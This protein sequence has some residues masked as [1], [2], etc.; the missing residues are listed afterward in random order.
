[1]SNRKES[2]LQLIDSYT[3]KH[4]LN[5]SLDFSECSAYTI[6]LDL[7][8][9]RTNVS[10]ILNQ[11]HKEG[12]LIKLTGRPTLYLSSNAIS[13]HFPY[14]VLPHTI[15]SKESI[16]SYLTQT[17]PSSNMYSNIHMIGSEKNG[18]LYNSTIQILPIIFYPFTSPQIF[19]LRGQ[20]GVG[21][22]YFLEQLLQRGKS[23]GRFP[24]E[25][26]ILHINGNNLLRTYPLEVE[27]LKEKKHSIIAITIT[28]TL[29]TDIVMSFINQIQYFFELETSTPPLIA[30]LIDES[31]K[32]YSQYY[33]LTPF[34]A[35]F[36]P[37]SD[38]PLK[39]ILRLI[40]DIISEECKRLSRNVQ[41]SKKL[42]ISLLGMNYTSNI[43][44]LK[45][46]IIYAFTFSAFHS[47]PN[48]DLPLV[49]SEILFPEADLYKTIA[50]SDR[51]IIDALPETILFKPA[52]PINFEELITSPL[53]SK[54]SFVDQTKQ[55][56]QTSLKEHLLSLP[57]NFDTSSFPTC[58][59][60]LKSRL[61]TIFE[62]T[63]LI[64]DSVLF[65][66][67]ISLIEQLAL[68]NIHR[69]AYIIDPLEEEISEIEQ[70]LCNKTAQIVISRYS[71]PD[72]DIIGDIKAIVR[73][74]LQCITNL[75]YPIIFITHG[76]ELASCYA[77]QLNRF[78]GR[79][80]F[81][82]KDFT[83]KMEQL[84]TTK[85]VKQ[86]STNIKSLNS[87]RGTFLF[88]DSVSLTKMDSK[89]FFDTQSLTFSIYPSSIIYMK[90]SVSIIK[91]GNAN[92]IIPLSSK[93]IQVKG[94]Y[95]HYLNDYTLN[96]KKERDSD[97][98]IKWIQNL[99]PTLNGNITR[100][101]LYQLLIQI[102]NIYSYE[103]NNQLILDFIFYGNWVLNR[104]S[105]KDMSQ[106]NIKD[107]YYDSESE[108]F[109]NLKQKISN[110]QELN[111]FSFTESDFVVLYDCL[112]PYLSL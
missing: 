102:C 67:M 75:A 5:E 79:R 23:I 50:S 93:I 77:I 74:T 8:I 40:L 29:A 26:S 61:T 103:P 32:N 112:L 94:Q 89:L 20:F 10:R 86:L 17:N 48:Q 64:Y 1:M 16:R 18:S 95:Q 27:K 104:I 85:F 30:L 111:P 11:L 97:P 72:K 24:K 12:L 45:N 69:N 7:N 92:S 76:N 49:L 99:Y 88:V 62:N 96:S 73:T 13:K 107:L 70:T 9:D 46:N 51:E 81:F 65:E 25:H 68:G 19:T 106:Y 84:G 63:A 109:K 101:T 91:N 37:L 58:N 21:K 28:D 41:A 57:V 66:Y 98:Y 22:H 56:K 36:P 54:A 83:T 14:V 42:I 108:L 80:M 38:R 53:I 100:E 6:A 39:E 31:V 110:S 3:R 15:S 87:K 34:N 35:Y 82:A 60:T 44:Q 4:I 52:H 2:I 78:Y 43:R 33:E 105:K 71:L 59:S 47:N 90:E 55:K